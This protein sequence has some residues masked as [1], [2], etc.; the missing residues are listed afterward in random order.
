MVTVAVVSWNTRELLLRCLRSLAPA[1]EAGRA[2]V[3]VVDNASTDGSA[4]AARTEAP[5]AR[6]LEPGENLGYGPAVNLVARQTGSEWIAAANADI[7]LEPGALQA[8][9]AAASEPGVGAAAPRLVLPDGST[10]HSVHHFPTLPFTLAFNLGL[11]RVGGRLGDRLALEGQWNP[12]RARE[13]DWALGAFLL[14]KREAFD[15][16]GG[17]DEDQWMYAEDL[18]LA[19]RLRDAEL[20]HALRAHSAGPT[21]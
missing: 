11:R 7:A 1:V 17:F 12:E 8:L 4:D 20:G 14:V 16:V 5:W 15:A 18:D 9:V 19:W 21:H 10:Q 13:V 3:W 2:S 6:V